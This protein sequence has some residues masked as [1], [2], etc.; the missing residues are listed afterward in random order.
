[1]CIDIDEVC[2]PECQNEY[3]GNLETSNDNRLIDYRFIINTWLP[4][5]VCECKQISLHKNILYKNIKIH[6]DT[7]GRSERDASEISLKDIDEEVT[8]GDKRFA[9]SRNR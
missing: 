3:F 6:K 4:G 9:R 7:F 5:Q 1:M 8:K 2:H